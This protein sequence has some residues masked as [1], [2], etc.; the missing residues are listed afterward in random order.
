MK[1]RYFKGLQQEKILR[2]LQSTKI[3]N[4]KR[5]VFSIN[6]DRTIRHSV[7]ET[8]DPYL[9]PDTKVNSKWN[10]SLNVKHKPIKHEKI[11]MTLI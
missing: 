7:K 2:D 10:I 1:D 4:G 3:I 6:S 11:F 8:Q 5:R 9:T